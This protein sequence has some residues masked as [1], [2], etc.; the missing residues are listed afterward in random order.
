[1]TDDLNMLKGPMTDHIM[2]DE[3]NKE[4]EIIK[5]I[6]LLFII[7]VGILILVSVIGWDQ[8][9]TNKIIRGENSAQVNT[10]LV[11][12]AILQSELAAVANMIGGIVQFCNQ[13]KAEADAT[14]A[15]LKKL[16][17]TTTKTTG[18][19]GRSK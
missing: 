18:F 8:I 11:T 12:K 9:Q 3:K 7:F 6:K 14:E 15:R 17:S 13:H 2:R 10:N 1:M 19:F 16:E 5:F 4:D